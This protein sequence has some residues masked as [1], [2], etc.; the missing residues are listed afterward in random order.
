M[1]EIKTGIN[2]WPD[3]NY[4]LEKV[5][6]LKYVDTITKPENY[7]GS[8]LAEQTIKKAE[9]DLDFL[10]T[11]AEDKLENYQGFS[12]F[13]DAAV[14]KYYCHGILSENE[15]KSF[16]SFKDR[17][18]KI[19][20]DIAVD[21]YPRL[22]N[23]K[24]EVES[25]KDYVEKLKDT[26]ISILNR[27]SNYFINQWEIE[28]PGDHLYEVY[29][30]DTKSEH[31]DKLYKVN[32]QIDELEN[33][34]KS[35]RE[36]KK[37]AVR[38]NDFQTAEYLDNMIKKAEADIEKVRNRVS[39]TASEA[40]ALHR[41][42]D[43]TDNY[44]KKVGYNLLVSPLDNLDGSICCLL[45]L[46]IKQLDLEDDIKNGE[47]FFNRLD[48]FELK[49]AVNALRGLL[50]RAHSGISAEL[51]Q[52]ENM[53]IKMLLAPVR[54]LLSEV[55]NLLRQFE[56]NVVS[57]VEELFSTILKG[58]ME[59][60]DN[61]IDCLYF[62]S[63]ADF[64]FE[65]IDDF[66]EETEAKIVDLYKFLYNQ[67]DLFDEDSITIGK[68]ARIKSMYGVLTEFSKA[69]ETID[70]FSLSEGLEEWIESFLIK[71]GYGTK[72][73]HKT[74]DFDKISLEGCIDPVD[75]SYQDRNFLPKDSSDLYT[76]NLEE[77]DDYKEF[78]K[79][80]TPITYA[81]SYKEIT[82]DNINTDVKELENEIKKYKSD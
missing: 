29:D 44:L 64:C 11:K 15:E 30:V 77:N 74:G 52:I 17:L 72:Y 13:K 39:Y 63:F 56:S 40:Y 23:L 21:I 62:E 9:I 42:A 43:N 69:L 28:P 3:F 5:P 75:G 53:I 50:I 58:D 2:Y 57:D 4:S 70:R 66:F 59:N 27:Y 67:V 61:I 26:E 73:N 36:E 45:K 1:S 71:S 76:I 60:P 47:E 22:I 8:E 25:D 10:I 18:S 82:E 68:K 65:E 79:D 33:E 41:K 20:G 34:V 31:Y 81:C 7:F 49:R 80:Y 16:N 6:P 51:E 46:L 14:K 55:V 12:D 37:K 78:K 48:L 38:D 19:D 24:K 35:I 54:V 32:K